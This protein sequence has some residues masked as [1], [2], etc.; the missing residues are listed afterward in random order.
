MICH[1][2]CGVGQIRSDVRPILMISLL[3]KNSVNDDQHMQE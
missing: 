2:L 1:Y 3:G